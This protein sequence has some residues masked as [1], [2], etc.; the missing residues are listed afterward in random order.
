L[1]VNFLLGTTNQLPTPSTFLYLS[2]PFFTFLYLSLTMAKISGIR[3]VARDFEIDQPFGVMFTMDSGEQ[4]SIQMDGS[5]WREAA[6]IVYPE[7]MRGLVGAT[8]DDM[9][10]HV[11]EETSV[12]LR[13]D[14]GEYK[15]VLKGSKGRLFVVI[16]GG[17]RAVYSAM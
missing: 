5:N 12:L 9:E 17:G 10:L 3:R 8:V 4:L 15:F 2:L 1:V 11:G 16:M 7:V 6:E 13:T 14:K